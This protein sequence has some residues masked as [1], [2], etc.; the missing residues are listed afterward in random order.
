ML[1]SLE[2]IEDIPGGKIKQNGTELGIYLLQ[3]IMLT[4]SVL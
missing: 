1:Q 3:T 4:L 2:R